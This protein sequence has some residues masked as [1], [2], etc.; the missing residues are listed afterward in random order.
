MGQALSWLWQWFH[1]IVHAAALIKQ[2]QP[3]VYQLD[4]NKTT[5][6]FSLES[7]IPI[8][9][10]IPSS[11][12]GLSFHDIKCDWEAQ[13]IIIMTVKVMIRYLFW[14]IF[15]VFLPPWTRFQSP[16]ESSSG[17]LSLLFK[18]ALYEILMLLLSFKS[19]WTIIYL[20]ILFLQNLVPTLLFG[21]TVCCKCSGLQS[22]EGSHR[23]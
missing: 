21:F 3:A 15:L 7:T 5:F 17:C 19:L 16:N 23:P 6:N 20:L 10:I 11:Y 14:T 12:I 4:L 8:F 9:V 2:E 18:A 13:I 22:A 1:N